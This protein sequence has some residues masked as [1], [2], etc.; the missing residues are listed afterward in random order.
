MFPSKTC[1]A[2]RDKG[3]S[4]MRR[5][6]ATGPMSLPRVADDLDRLLSSLRRVDGRGLLGEADAERG[7]VS[8]GRT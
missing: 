2:G 5:R 4:G 6:R 3:F 7:G 1:G 8:P